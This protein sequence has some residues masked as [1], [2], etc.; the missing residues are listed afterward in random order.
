MAFPMNMGLI[1]ARGI[2]GSHVKQQH[3]S[4][5]FVNEKMTI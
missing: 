5:F 4:A 3:F 1:K 2:D